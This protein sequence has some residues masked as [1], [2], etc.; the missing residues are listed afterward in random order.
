MMTGD[1]NDVDGDCDVFE[2][3]LRLIAM[4]L[5]MKTAVLFVKPLYCLDRPFRRRLITMTMVDDYD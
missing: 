1:Y 2:Y 4:A 3:Y 5:T